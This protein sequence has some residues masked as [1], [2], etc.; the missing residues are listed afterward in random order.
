VQLNLNV[1]G[2]VTDPSALRFKQA[3]VALEPA[4]GAVW[5]TEVVHLGNPTPNVIDVINAPLELSVSAD[6]GDLTMVRQDMDEPNHAHLGQKLL[7]YGRIQPGDSTI[8]FRYRLGAALGALRVDML[9]PHPVDELLVIAPKG[10]LSLASEQLTA[11]PPRQFEGTAY[12]SWNATQMPAQRLVQLRAKGIP[13]QQG[14]LLLPL[15]GF[16]AVMTGMLIWF[17]RKRLPQGS[18]A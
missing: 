6:A 5:V 10:S 17:V 7:V 15:L 3:L 4:V 2:L 8:A 11:Q 13:M 9:Y 14:L 18:A 12:D 1:P 16:F